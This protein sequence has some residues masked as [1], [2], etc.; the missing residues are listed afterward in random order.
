MTEELTLTAKDGQELF[1]YR[2]LP[3]EGSEIRATVQIAHG[4]AEHGVRYERLAQA[5]N[6]EGYVVYA[7]DHRGHGKSA[8]GDANLGWGGEDS[9][10]ACADDLG[11]IGA[12]IAEQHPDL[13]RV[14]FGHSMGSFMTLTY[15]IEHSAK[16]DVAVLSGTSNGGDLLQKAGRVVA[17]LERLRQGPRGKSKLLAF[18]SFGSFNNAFKPARTDF[19]WL[20]KDEAEVDKYVADPW[21]G[22]DVTNQWW[23]DFLGGLIE[24]GDDAKLRK[25]RADLPIYVFAGD[26][27]PVG[28]QGKNVCALV[29][30]LRATGHARVKQTLYPG[31]RHEMINERERDQV[32]RELID[33]L[34]T[35]LGTC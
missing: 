11:T 14:L 2:W 12:H 16:V 8:G 9:W 23:V 34:G 6:A 30:R 27:D 32:T 18:L 28:A 25:I 20:S 17:K 26:Q 21:C 5:L 15:L 35:T 10:R 3:P 24:L 29:D 7:N 1:V 31:G 33:W 19:D 22:F 4:M 13:P